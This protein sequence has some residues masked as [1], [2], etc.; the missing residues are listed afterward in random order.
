M[1]QFRLTAK[2]AKELKIMELGIPQEVAIPYDD[3]Y[4]HFVRVARKRVYI[5]IH[6]KTRLAIALPNYE[7]GGLENLFS[8]FAVQLGV[9]A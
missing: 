7:I 8:C 9:V 3:W 2:M 1:P 5:F 4:V 6:I